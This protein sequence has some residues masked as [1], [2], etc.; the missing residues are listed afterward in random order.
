MRANILY[1]MTEISVGLRSHCRLTPGRERTDASSRTVS[2]FGGCASGASEDSDAQDRASHRVEVEGIA[3]PSLRKTNGARAK[4]LHADHTCG[5]GRVGR[6]PPI[7]GR[8][9]WRIFRKRFRTAGMLAARHR[10]RSWRS[11]DERKLRGD[12]WT[13][14]MIMTCAGLGGCARCRS[15]CQGMS[16]GRRHAPVGE[17]TQNKHGDE[18]VPHG[19]AL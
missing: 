19:P 14:G 18:A 13:T 12:A 8:Q 16:Q 17:R 1:L 15:T 5:I 9:G 11:E 3:T 6:H 7:R 4:T 2:S 10:L